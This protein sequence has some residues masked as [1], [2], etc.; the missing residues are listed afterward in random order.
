MNYRRSTARKVFEVCNNIF[1]AFVIFLTVTPFIMILASSFSSIE[2]I[3]QQLVY[4][5]PVGFTL[6]GYVQ[7]FMD[8]S[9]F[10]AYYN[11]LWFVVVGVAISLLLTMSAAYAL[12]RK[13]Y[14]MRSQM[15]IIVTITMFF[16]GGL[17]PFYIL[18]NQ[19]G[20]FDT[21]WSIVLP[22]AVSAFNLVMARVFMQSNVP[23]ELAESA[24]IDGANDIHIF[25]LIALPLSKAIIAVL[26]LF[27]GVG[28]WNSWF[29]EMLFLR[30]ADYMPLSLFLR[31]LIIL[32]GTA[33]STL[34][35]QN[36]LDKQMF[37]D[38]AKFMAIRER[39]KYGS[40]IVTML[41]IMMVYPLLQKYFA[42]GVM[43]GA[44][45]E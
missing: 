8:G 16:S 15:M 26:A 10:V 37:Q 45:K 33:A 23:D 42:K 14:S 36:E 41:P 39:M 2:A 32:G 24:K 40:V 38:P 43:I 30:N 28:R 18:I 21:R 3:V 20:L 9:I 13:Y 17:V 44:L 22:T 31:R 27:Y 19:L 35:A 6:E 12:S 4:L 1:L 29:N 11:T 25:F 34:G 7:I 5:L